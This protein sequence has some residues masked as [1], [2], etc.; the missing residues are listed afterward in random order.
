M[1][2]R[3]GSCRL[4]AR[5]CLDAPTS[6]SWTP[7]HHVVLEANKANNLTR[8]RTDASFVPPTGS[9]ELQTEWSSTRAA[10][11]ET[12]PSLSGQERQKMDSGLVAEKHAVGT[13][14]SAVTEEEVRGAG[15]RFLPFPPKKVSPGALRLATSCGIR[16][17]TF[18]IESPVEEDL[19]ERRKS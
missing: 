3:M 7:R 5:F 10:T 13:S 8:S 11:S 1:P 12:D 19:N 14:V 16:A 9:F 4:P 2:L 18:V 6:R 15:I 17:G